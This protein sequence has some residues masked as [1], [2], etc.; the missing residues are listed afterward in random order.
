MKKFLQKVTMKAYMKKME[1]MKQNPNPNR[2]LHAMDVGALRQSILTD[3][4]VGRLTM[5]Q[6][7]E[8]MKIWETL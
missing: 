7:K 4:F 1:T 3:V 6:G 5:A 8:L 2:F